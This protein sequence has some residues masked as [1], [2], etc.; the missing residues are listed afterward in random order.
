MGVGDGVAI[1]LGADFSDAAKDRDFVGGFDIAQSVD[2]RREVAEMRHGIAFREQFCGGQVAG[3]RLVIRMRKFPSVIAAH[4][5]A[6]AVGF[7]GEAEPH[8]EIATCIALQRRG[9]RKVKVAD[10]QHNVV[11]E[12]LLLR[13][14]QGQQI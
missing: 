3:K 14:R 11:T 7:I 4:F 5:R 10:G 9:K 6:R 2:G 12:A 8:P 13:R 1:A